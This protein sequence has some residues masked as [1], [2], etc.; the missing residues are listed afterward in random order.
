MLLPN[1][2]ARSCGIRVPLKATKTNAGRKFL[3]VNSTEMAIH[4]G[5]RHAGWAGLIVAGTCFI[6]PAADAPNVSGPRR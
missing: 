6:V 5:H 2:D 1:V 3:A 4:I